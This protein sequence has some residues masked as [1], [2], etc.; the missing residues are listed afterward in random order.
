MKE[1]KKS[2]LVL[3]ILSIVLGFLLP[4]VGLVLGIIGLV[5]ANSH[6]KESEYEDKVQSYEHKKQ[7]QSLKQLSK[8][9]SVDVSG[10]RYMMRLIEHFGIESIK[11]VKNYH[12][13]PEPKQEMIDKFF[14]VG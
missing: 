11:K 8:R 6:Q 10:L 1:K 9:F 4:V 13:S 7:G 3:G 14:L 5:L 12:Y 2:S